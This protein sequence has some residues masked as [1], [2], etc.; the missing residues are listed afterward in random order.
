MLVALPPSTLNVSVM[1]PKLKRPEGRV[2]ER[3]ERFL[4][5]RSRRLEKQK[6]GE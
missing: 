4:F 3:D 6:S 2:V 1:P 5:R